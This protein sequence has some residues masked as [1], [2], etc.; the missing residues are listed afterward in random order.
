MPSAGLP[1]GAVNPTGL[2]PRIPPRRRGLVKAGAQRS[3]GTERSGAPPAGFSLDGVA[4]GGRVVEVP[5]GTARRRR[6]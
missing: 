5:G 1:A 3:G 6:S 2:D 4:S